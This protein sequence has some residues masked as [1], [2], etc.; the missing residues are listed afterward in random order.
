MSLIPF[1]VAQSNLTSLSNLSVVS[2]HA[3]ALDVCFAVYGETSTS[4]D[5]IE[6]FYEADA[7]NYENPILTATSRS[8]IA[9]IFQ[10]SRQF[11]TVDVPR[12]LA[13][14][15]TL[16]R[17][18]L[19]RYMNNPL[20]QA[21]R[22]WNDIGEI[23]ESES[24]D[25]TR[26]IIV[27]HK[28][29]LLV[30]PGLHVD[31]ASHVRFEPSEPRKPNGSP[32]E[33]PH[34]PTY[35]SLPVPG[36]WLSLPSPFHF[37]LHVLTRLSFNEQGKVTHHRDFWDVKDLMGLVPG[38]SLAQWIGTRIAARSLA[39]ASRFWRKDPQASLE[40]EGSTKTSEEISPSAQTI[41]HD[42]EKGSAPSVS[43]V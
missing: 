43:N 8:L 15:Y 17:L 12:P 41:I 6:R 20:F 42:L 13:V 25:G 22:V 1:P 34:H 4:T 30:L 14:F 27:E 5:V 21:L 35:P 3:T 39:C 28:L 9:D 32:L 23:S 16:F 18:K 36:T 40:E 37:Q 26:R 29:N 11:T 24:F 38:V 2:I 7:S 33:E 19:P 10:L 31:S